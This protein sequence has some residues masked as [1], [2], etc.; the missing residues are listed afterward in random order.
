MP[1]TQTGNVPHPFVIPSVP[2]GS[3]VR[4]NKNLLQYNFAS[5]WAVETG[6]WLMM[7]SM[8]ND[9]RQ[10]TL[11]LPSLGIGGGRICYDRKVRTLYCWSPSVLPKPSDWSD[12]DHV[13]L[14]SSLT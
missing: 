6:M 1:W 14:S 4:I 13:S 11:E 7:K 5:Y 12:N 8:F 10:K 2:L 9:F 3:F